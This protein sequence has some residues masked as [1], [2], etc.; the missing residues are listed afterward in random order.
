MLTIGCAALQLVGADSVVL[1]E[2]VA[3]AGLLPCLMQLF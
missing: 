1:D 3:E 2:A